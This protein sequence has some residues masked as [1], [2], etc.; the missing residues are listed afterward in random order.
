MDINYYLNLVI[1]S[2]YQ[3]E[4]RCPICKTGR[5][6]VESNTLFYQTDSMDSFVHFV[7]CDYVFSGILKCDNNKCLT[8]VSFGGKADLEQCYDGTPEGGIEYKLTPKWFYPPLSIFNI[9]EGC[10]ESIKNELCASFSS[11][12]NDATASCS[13][14]RVA[15]ERFMDVQGIES[16]FVNREGKEERKKLHYRIEDFAR[17]DPSN[18]SRLMALKILGNEAMH[19]GNISKD[20]AI[21]AYEVISLVLDEFYVRR[22]REMRVDAISRGLAEKHKP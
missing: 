2:D 12:F 10:P 18:G 7:E 14:I 13:H 1:D 8:P 20:D 3:T 15:I 21:A 17:R 5:L 22:P 11:F 16:H 19:Q 6:C 9:P 4:L